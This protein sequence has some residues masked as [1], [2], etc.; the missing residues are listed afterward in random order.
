MYNV[1]TEA[2]S[3]V[4]VCS[5]KAISVTYGVC[6]ALGIQHKMRMRYTV[7]CGLSRSTIFSHVIS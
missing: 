6:I 4:I 5:G 1:N 3:C 7:N 2:R